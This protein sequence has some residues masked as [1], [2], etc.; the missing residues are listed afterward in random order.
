MALDKDV[1]GAALK[2]VRD[3]FSNKTK[4]QLIAIYGDEDAIRLAACK[5]E[6][7]AIINHFKA[8]AVLTVPGTGLIAP[9]GGGAVTGTAATGTLS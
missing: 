1:L 9:S 5:A 7:A 8:Q 4:D 3:N 2:T 6:A